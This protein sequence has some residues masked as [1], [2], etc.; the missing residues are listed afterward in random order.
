MGTFNPI[1][2]GLGVHNVIYSNPPC[3]NRT[4]I[5][6]VGTATIQADDTLCINSDRFTPVFNPKGGTWT[7]PGVT[8]W[9]W[10]RF[11]AAIAGS[12]M[13]ELIYTY[14]SCSDTLRMTVIDIDAGSNMTVCPAEAPFS[15]GGAPL[16]GVWTGAGVVDS[17][18]G[19]FDPGFNGGNNF[20]T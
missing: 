11:D 8:N 5:I 2:A 15:L 1:L 6:T 14:G 18:L 3:A 7:G 4:K 13:H 16:G 12:G 20:N 19:I 17:I 9:Y 10:C